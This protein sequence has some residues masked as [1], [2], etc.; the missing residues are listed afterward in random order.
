M[1]LLCAKRDECTYPNI[2][3]HRTP[4][5]KDDGCMKKEC[6][7]WPGKEVGPCTPVNV[8]VLLSIEQAVNDL[9]GAL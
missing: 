1:K 4:H 6:V 3:T 5:S 9:K 2:C 8:S 7:G